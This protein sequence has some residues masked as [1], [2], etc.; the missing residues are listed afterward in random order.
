LAKRLDPE[1]HAKHEAT[2]DK[3]TEIIYLTYKDDVDPSNG[4]TSLSHDPMC[5]ICDVNPQL[6]MIIGL[7]AVAQACAGETVAIILYYRPSIEAMKQYVAQVCFFKEVDEEHRNKITIGSPE[8][9]LGSSAAVVHFV[10][11]QSR[12]LGEKEPKGHSTDARRRWV[13]L[14]RASRKLY[15]YCEHMEFSTV[16]A[17]ANLQ[18]EFDSKGVCIEIEVD[19]RN[20]VPQALAEVIDVPVT[21]DETRSLAELGI[22]IWIS[23][24]DEMRN[25]STDKGRMASCLGFMT[26]P[27][28]WRNTWDNMKWYVENVPVPQL[29]AYS[30]DSSYQCNSRSLDEP[31]F[32][33]L[34]ILNIQG[35]NA[36]WGVLQ[37]V[38]L[39]E[40]DGEKHARLHSSCS[41]LLSS[42]LRLCQEKAIL[43][44][45]CLKIENHKMEKE[46]IGKQEFFAQHCNSVRPSFC[47][48]SGPDENDDR[49][50]KLY[51][52]MGTPLDREDVTGCVFMTKDYSIIGAI[53]YLLKQKSQSANL[54]QLLCRD[55]TAENSS[56][57]G[58]D[59]Y[60]SVCEAVAAFTDTPSE[61][62]SR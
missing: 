19:P 32:I 15:L 31:L 35:P 45:A 11:I 47:I 59:V 5:N 21:E 53:L 3:S 17:T 10:C 41:R 8:A 1:T 40:W 27:G 42:A 9:L 51:T 52:G 14:S 16:K 60:S 33:P 25:L 4:W 56:V 62:S 43:P 24:F 22:S 34:L 18:R 54:F 38:A 28:E 23:F 57:P 6:F 39:G 12:T 50:F 58:E 49:L 13:A 61:Y 26:S 2:A 29:P 7:T 37:F 48:R 46:K 30:D 55:A 36:A 44:S 20:S